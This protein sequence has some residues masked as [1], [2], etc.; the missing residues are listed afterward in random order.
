MRKRCEDPKERERLRAIADGSYLPILRGE[1]SYTAKVTEAD[2]LA[3]RE[4]RAAGRELQVIAEEFGVTKQNVS[5]IV[6]GKTWKHVGGPIMESQPARR[7]SDDDV[8]EVRRLHSSG[9]NQSDIARR[10]EVSQGHV[11]NVVNF[12]AHRGVLDS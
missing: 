1:G 9:M 10:Y 11:S 6:T 7:L 4:H 8:S 5:Y 3:M 12:H 2:V